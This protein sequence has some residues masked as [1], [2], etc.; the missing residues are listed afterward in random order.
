MASS[1]RRERIVVDSIHG[2]IHLSDQEWNV[3]NTGS[4][5]RL[6]QIKQIG[7][8]HFTYPN[9]THTRFA[10]SLGVLGIMI[11]VLR[12]AKEGGVRL[13]EKMRENLR[14]AALLHDIGHYPYSHVMESIDSVKLTEEMI[15]DKGAVKR[16]L[17]MT[18]RRYPSHEEVGRLIVTCQEDIVQAIGGPERAAAVAD[19]FTRSEAANP[20]LSKL[21]HSSLD[22]DR[23]DYLLR[24]SRAA[25][26]PYGTID[27]NYILNNVM[28]SKGGLLGVSRK[29]LPAVEQFLLA[30][31]FMHRAVYYH[32]TTVALEEACRQLLR[33]LRSRSTRNYDVPKDGFGVEKWVKSPE[34]GTF[35]DAFVDG[36]VQAA[37]SDEDKVVCA[38]ASCIFRRR[39]PKLLKEV[40]A[41][42]RAGDATGGVA[43]S[44]F[45]ANFRHQIAGLAARHSLDPRLFL[46]WEAKPLKF[47]ERGASIRA[48]DV[49]K[50]ADEQEE[51][52]IKV[53]VEGGDELRSIMDIDH[54]L[55]ALCAGHLFYALRLYVVCP[56]DGVVEALRN[57]VASWDRDS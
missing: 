33:R 14:L 4:F 49:D 52:A 36:V 30:R 41:L 38:L 39:P 55:M 34:L 18:T 9:A 11:R 54:S 35:T 57:E 15:E 12:A 27:I 43:I 3:V 51:E 10:H 20:Q 21:I 31:H 2:D 40:S 42:L 22:M 28:V 7:M 44:L 5:Q 26:V 32:K 19:L 16:S 45:R 25:G 1:R 13:R 29:A 37:V 8:G 50:L 53:F 47:E 46:F 24:D 48:T 23:L 17:D 56:N 6:R